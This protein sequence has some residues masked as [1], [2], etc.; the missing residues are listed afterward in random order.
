[1]IPTP[2][3]DHPAQI[4][5]LRKLKK[6]VSFDKWERVL[7][8]F[9]FSY[10]SEDGWE[11]DR[12]VSSRNLIIIRI[13]KVSHCSRSFDSRFGYKRAKLALRIRI[14]KALCEAQFDLN[15][16]FKLNINKLEAKTLRHQPVRCCIRNR[17]MKSK[18]KNNFTCILPQI[19]KDK[20]GNCY[21]F[22]VDPE[23]NVRV[24]RE[25]LDDETWE[26]VASNRF[27]LFFFAIFRRC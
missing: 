26:L 14:I 27:V 8:R 15:A 22:Q 7:T 16:R 25:D 24:Y 9:T 21:W 17:N 4:K 23:A 13:G 3:A 20:L 12:S 18:D 5:L 1:M 6:T 11:L 2:S 10:S 19:G